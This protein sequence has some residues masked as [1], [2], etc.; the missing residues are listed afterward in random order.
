MP[1]HAHHNTAGQHDLD[2]S[3]PSRRHRRRKPGLGGRARFNG[4][5]QFHIEFDLCKSRR[6]SP[7]Q[8]R[9]ALS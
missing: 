5:W 2:Q 9:L 7:D 4:R 6:A 8:C 3:F 1:V